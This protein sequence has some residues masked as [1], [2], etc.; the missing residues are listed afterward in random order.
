MPNLQNGGDGTKPREEDERLSTSRDKGVVFALYS[1]KTLVNC[2]PL[3]NGAITHLTFSADPVIDLS[4]SPRQNDT[5]I[6]KKC[7]RS[8]ELDRTPWEEAFTEIGY[9]TSPLILT[10]LEY[11]GMDN[12]SPSRS[13]IS[14]VP[15][16]SL[17]ASSKLTATW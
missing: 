14:S 17:M 16:G 4:I 9:M 12:I 7:H 3:K 6:Y 15:P 2:K 13:T 5:S 1:H 10:V 11:L 8:M